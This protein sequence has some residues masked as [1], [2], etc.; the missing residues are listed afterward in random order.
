[1]LLSNIA[2]E[3]GVFFEGKDVEIAGIH[4]LSEADSSQMSFFDNVRY[5]DL[6]QKTKAAAVLCEE[7]YASLLPQD[8]KVLISDE[9]YLKLA[10]ASKLFRYKISTKTSIPSLG[11]NCDID[12]SVIFG[13][14]V[15]VEDDVTILA[16]CYIGDN[17]T[18]GSGTFLHPNIT[19]YHHCEVG[20][21][22]IIHAGV[23]IGS[24]G[25]GFAHTKEGTH[26]KIYQNGNVI[27]GNDVEIGA[28]CAIDRAV[29]GTTHIRDGGKDG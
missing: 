25:F 27:I 12:K 1:M 26:V 9:P 11:N 3:I 14:N 16:N 18:I 8:T 13:V 23:V 6:L 17:V 24:D 21:N 19:I 20:Q 5:K 22:C 28:N 10:L 29:F 4:T 15:V 7:K 2:K